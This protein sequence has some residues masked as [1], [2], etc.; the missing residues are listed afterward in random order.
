VTQVNRY[1]EAKRWT[2][3]YQMVL[4]TDEIRSYVIF[5]YAHINW[6]SS[7]IAGALQGRGG[8]QS[9][10]AGFNAGNGTGKIYLFLAILPA[11]RL[12]IIAVFG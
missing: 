2:N 10:L 12:D 1:D 11:S 5:N 9:A 3:T 6:T 8:L 4:A 7:N